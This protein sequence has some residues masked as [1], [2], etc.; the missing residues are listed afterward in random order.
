MLFFGTNEFALPSLER[1]VEQRQ[2][3]LACVTQPDR[4]QGRGLKRRPSPVKVAAQRLRLP[5]EEPE[6]LR[7]ALAH[8]HA[9]QPDAG[10]VISYGKLVPPELLALPAHG[11]LGV[12]PS[13]LPKYRGASPIAWPLLQGDAATGVTVFRL[14]E[15]LDAGDIAHQREVAVAPGE[16]AVTLSDR[17]SRLGAE[18]LGQ[19]L[20][21]L[22]RGTATFHAQDER[23]ASYAPKLKK[24]QGRV[25]WGQSAC[26]IDRLARAMTP[27]PGAYTHW[28]GK[29]LKIWKTSCRDQHDA[30]LA[31]PAAGPGTITA[32]DAQGIAVAAGQ[33]EVLIHELQLAG[34]RRM[35]AQEFLA[36]HP[37]R[38][39]SRFASDE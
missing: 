8:W 30:P 27:W 10:V 34:K 23:L 21:E 6:D 29:I 20:E 22:E 1:L 14:N 33:G 28:Q 7:R 16:N 25:D 31:P 13:L 36:G 15:R 2:E 17:L 26:A 4:P 12:H 39:G 24:S 5:I 3:V 19:T 35:S 18:L 37:M 38:V 11:M 32:A 9:L